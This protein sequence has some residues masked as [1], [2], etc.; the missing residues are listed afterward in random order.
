MLVLIFIL[1]WSRLIICWCWFWSLYWADQGWYYADAGADFDTEPTKVW[2]WQVRVG[3]CSHVQRMATQGDTMK[4]CVFVFIHILCICMHIV[5]LYF[6]TYCVFVFVHL[7]C[8]CICTQIVYLYLYTNCVFVF[9]HLFVK[10]NKKHDFRV[11]Q[12]STRGPLAE[13]WFS[14]P[15]SFVCWLFVI[16][17]EG[18]HSY[19]YLH[20]LYLSVSTHIQKTWQWWLIS[21]EYWFSR[22]LSLVWSCFGS[23]GFLNGEHLSWFV[24][25]FCVW[26]RT[27]HLTINASHHHS[28]LPIVQLHHQVED[29]LLSGAK[30]LDPR[31]S[32]FA[33]CSYDSHQIQVDSIWT[34]TKVLGSKKDELRIYTFC[35]FVTKSGCCTGK[36][37][38]KYKC[39]ITKISQLSRAI[40][41][42]CTSRAVKYF[43]FLLHS[44]A[45]GVCHVI[46]TDESTFLSFVKRT[47]FPYSCLFLFSILLFILALNTLVYSRFE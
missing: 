8:I 24:V 20:S 1:S 4:T 28:Q 21:I 10:G 44:V 35:L 31:G 45:A 32:S 17:L 7:L 19:L 41:C 39:K 5:Y 29:C 47:C 15:V 18:L 46:I 6:H 22:P 12:L 2:T 23:D 3:S 13:H 37:R 33:L 25:F 27:R 30:F 42:C 26:F 9:V 11:W 14:R 16:T 34:S 38:C 40:E 43:V 36:F